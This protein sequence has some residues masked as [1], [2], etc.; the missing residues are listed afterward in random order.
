MRDLQYKYNDGGRARYFSKA[1]VRDCGVRAFAIASGLDYKE[2]Y[3]M[4][5][6]I[7][8][9]SPRNGLPRKCFNK[10]AQ[11]LGGVEWHATMQIGSGCTTHL[12]AGEIPM[13]GRIVCNVSRHYVA[14]IDGVVNDT[15]DCTRDGERCVYGYW[16]FNNK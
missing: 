1:N 2:V 3:N 13:Q 14:V 10:A 11:M 4:M 12:R 6:K 15:Y 5:R 8:G 7:Y 9:Q 16:V